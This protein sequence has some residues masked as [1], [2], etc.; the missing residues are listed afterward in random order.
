MAYPSVSKPY[1]L[2]PSNL[3]G[4]Q[5]FSGATRM[6]PIT[7]TATPL[8]L[9]QG[10]LVKLNASGSIIA[11]TTVVPTTRDGAQ[12]PEAGVIGA[13]LG[14]EYTTAGGPLF[15][16]MRNNYW[17]SAVGAQDAVGYIV[18]DPDTVFKVAV[19]SQPS[20]ANNSA[21]ALTSVGY[22]S[23][24]FVGSN[25]Y[26]VQANQ[27]LGSTANGNS[28]AGV[29]ANCPTAGVAGVVRTTG[30]GVFRVMDVVPETAVTI[31]TATSGAST[32]S[33]LNVIPSTGVQPGMQ[34]IVAGVAS[35]AGTPSSNT[36]VTA[37]S[38]TTVTI[39]P[40]L[41][42]A[43]ASG[44]GLTFIGYPEV[45]VKLNFGQHSYYNATGV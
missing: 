31:S 8:S 1:G 10:D 21:A 25:M 17:T 27:V 2:V 19:L 41:A 39:S 5:V 37:V 35:G 22:V 24:S 9:F 42:N 7:A 23:P 33:A 16:K 36:T 43:P 3:I 12:A 28:F 13:F 6:F 32:T 11:T 40:A 14:A 30:N 34:V 38:G 26:Y 15:G 45:L 4:G 18:H 44:T 20:G 29:T